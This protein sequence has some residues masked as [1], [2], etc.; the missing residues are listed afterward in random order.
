MSWKGLKHINQ[1]ISGEEVEAED[2]VVV[3]A[4]DLQFN[5]KL[6]SQFKAQTAILNLTLMKTKKA[7][8]KSAIQVQTKTFKQLNKLRQVTTQTQVANQYKI[9]MR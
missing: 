5:A 6:T 3:E 9:K 2:V 8:A 4:V 7:S 1:S